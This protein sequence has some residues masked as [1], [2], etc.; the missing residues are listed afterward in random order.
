MGLMI[1]QAGD[2][3]RRLQRA[4]TALS[5]SMGRSRVH[6]RL[7]AAVGVRIERS[8]TA[9]LRTLRHA[10]HA[11]RITEL[12]DLLMVRPPHVTR[13]VNALTEAG[14]VD[15][16]RDANDQRAQLVSITNSGIELVDRLDESF[17]NR[18]TGVLHDVPPEEIL[19]AARIISRIVEVSGEDGTFP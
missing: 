10:D 8:G 4:V 17:R 13:Q 7:T 12:A 14:L 3:V 18:L 16:T 19:K 11:V 9:L 5:Y 1:D 15:R 2:P 6:E